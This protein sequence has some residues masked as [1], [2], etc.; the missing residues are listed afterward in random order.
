MCLALLAL[1]LSLADPPAAA[2]PAPIDP[3]AEAPSRFATVDG[4]EVH[5]KSVGRGPSTLVLVHGWTCDMT[6]W[7][8][9]VPAF[10]QKAR[11]VLVDLPGSGKSDKPDVAYTMDLFAR[12]LDAVLRD[13]KVDRAVLVGHSNGTPAVRQ[14]YRLFPAK[15]AALVAVDGNL[16]PYGEPA[17][18]EKFAAR[19]S[20]PDYKEVAGQFIDGMMGP[21]ATPELRD[22]I[23][24]VMLS[25]PQHVMVSSIASLSDPR[26]WT[27]D[28][29]AVP[30]LVVLAQSPSWTP[31]YEAFVRRL[32]PDVDYQVHDGV[33]HFLMMEKPEMFNA[34]LLAFL[35]KHGLLGS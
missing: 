15:T 10:A 6:F 34:A 27:E 12:A 32:A 25:A 16:R 33:G 8:A 20:G 3:L 31:G 22:R 1:A 14:F 19:F 35:T 9:Q 5:Y 24:S 29:I 23:K 4:L 7:R 30:L 26:V 13:A 17:G 21:G 18:Y 28:K 2:A 11:L